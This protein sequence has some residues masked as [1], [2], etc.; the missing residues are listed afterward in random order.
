CRTARRR[1]AGEFRSP[2]ADRA[3]LDGT[4]TPRPPGAAGAAGRAPMRASRARST[5]RRPYRDR[6]EAPR[7]WRK[8]EL[9]LAAARRLAARPAGVPLRKAGLEFRRGLAGRARPPGGGKDPRRGRRDDAAL[10]TP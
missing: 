1:R 4:R 3:R 10:P 2:G 8:G 6:R 7:A 5:I 9:G